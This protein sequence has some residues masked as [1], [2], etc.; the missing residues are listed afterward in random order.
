MPLRIALAGLIVLGIAVTTVEA[1]SIA[2]LTTTQ[3]TVRAKA[4]PDECFSFLGTNLPFTT[5]PCLF[6][7]PK[8]NQ[9]YVWAM[10]KARHDM[11]FGTAANPQCIAQAGLSLDPSTWIPYR[12]PSW[13]CEFGSGPYSPWL[14]P[15]IIGDFRPP[16]IFLW[17]RAKAV[18]VEMTPKAPVTADN[19][20]G[21]DPVLASTRGIR[22]AATFGNLV[23]LAGPS[24]FGGLN[25]FFFQADTRA[26]L[27]SKTL[28]GLNNIRQFTV[29]RGQLYVS[30]GQTGIGGAV[31]RW[32]GSMTAA[33]CVSCLSFE[34][35]GSF[36]GMGVFITDHQG[37]LFVTTWP[38]GLPQSVAALY[39]SPPVPPEGLS[40]AHAYLW[41]RVWDANDYEPDPVVAATYAGG[42]LAS[43]DGY[44]YWGTMH[45]PWHA[46]AAFL[47]AHGAPTTNQ[48]WTEAVIGTFR[49]AAVFRGRN[50]AGK[51]PRIDLLYGSHIHPAFRPAAGAQP[52]RWEFVPNKMPPG[53]QVPLYGS[54]GF[55]NFYNNY[56][57]SMTVW[58]N[59]LWVGTMDWS[60]SADQ[61]TEFIAQAAGQPVPVEV[62]AFFSVQNFGGD[63]FFFQD[64]HT[65]AVAE[66][67][68]GVG[69]FT[70]Y[71]IRTMVPTAGSLF[72]GMANPNNLLTSPLG[73]RGGW[74]LIE[75][76]PAKTRPLN[77]LTHFTCEPL[78][79]PLPTR[80]RCT[81]GAARRAPAGGLVM[82]VIA[83]APL[84]PQ[85]TLQVPWLVWIPPGQTDVTF[86][87]HVGGVA[88]GTTA[89]FIAGLNGGTRAASLELSPGSVTAVSP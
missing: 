21:F 50:F 68:S 78:P 56:I 54:S 11:W 73:P 84:A 33:P 63:L 52:G 7:Q 58:D 53:R 2:G 61:G 40:V 75:M 29:F 57:W 5:P 35:V 8:V 83:F 45:V 32:N 23:M 62:K 30:V 34:V 15:A 69:N 1:Q 9:A 28:A 82:G 38:S 87:V 48:G 77:L 14:L 26:Y 64:S 49:T 16:Q 88:N 79:E 41:T 3:G 67:Q 36:D 51:R 89:I 24:L 13:A 85:V 59:R 72:L 65:P 66:S 76:M 6:S 4:Q 86:D 25:F 19:P 37:R 10:T 46:T 70:N 22:A 12:T 18:L 17:D 80:T 71:G 81:A 39:M 44:L 74:E 60:H 43:F 27:G 20:F 42:A 55:N 47:G 31:L